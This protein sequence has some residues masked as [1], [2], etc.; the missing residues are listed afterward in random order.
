MDKTVDKLAQMK[1][2]TERLV[3]Y[4]ASSD[5]LRERF[6]QR[7]QEYTTFWASLERLC[8]RYSLDHDA[9]VRRMQEFMSE[10]YELVDVVDTVASARGMM[11]AEHSEGLVPKG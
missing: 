5:R 2:V 11:P 6:D 3:R 10:V 9:A 4:A 1:E 8:K 7:L